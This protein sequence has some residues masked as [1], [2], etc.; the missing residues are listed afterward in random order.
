MPTRQNVHLPHDSAEVKALAKHYQS[1]RAHDGAHLVQG[2]EIH[3]GIT[4]LSRDATARRTAYLH[5]LQRLATFHAAANLV[6]NLAK[7]GSHRHLDESAV[8]H[9]AGQSK[10]LCAWTALRTDFCIRLGAVMDDI[11][12]LAQRFHIIY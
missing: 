3:L 11:G 10:D 7:R 5:R 9:L 1:A 12:Y 2:I 4:Q 8:I 6:H